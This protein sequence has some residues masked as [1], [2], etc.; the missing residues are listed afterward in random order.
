[1]EV[2]GWQGMLIQDAYASAK[3]QVQKVVPEGV[4]VS[5]CHFGSPA[6]ATLKSGIWITE[7]DRIPVKTLGEFLHVVNSES[8]KNRQ[9]DKLNTQKLNSEIGRYVEVSREQKNDAS[10]LLALPTQA[11]MEEILA[12]QDES[13]IQIKYVTAGNVAHVRAIKMDAHYWPTWHIIQNAKSP[14]GWE[15]TFMA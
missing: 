7:V 13:H 6:H 3:E 11:E 14:H 12:F 15:M 2:V 1:M 8:I 4:Y 9:E 5:C 10:S